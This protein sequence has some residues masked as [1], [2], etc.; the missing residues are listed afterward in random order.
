ML[1]CASVLS[2]ETPEDR[3]DAYLKRANPQFGSTTGVPPD[4]NRTCARGFRNL[5]RMGLCLAQRS[6]SRA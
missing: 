6:H 2:P 4:K 5:R 1:D 3:L